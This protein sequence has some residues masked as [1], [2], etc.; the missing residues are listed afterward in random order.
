MKK[1]NTKVVVTQPIHD[2]GMKLLYDSIEE[3]VVAPDDSIETVGKLLDES[4]EGVVVRYNRFPKELIDKAPNLKVIARHGIGVELIDVKY[5]T[6]EGIYV[7]N[8][9]TASTISVAEHT[10]T[11]M[12]ALAKNILNADSEL[13]RGNYA[14][15][16]KLGCTDLENK[17]LGI[18]GAGKIGLEVAK[19]CKYGFNMNVIAY[20]PYINI[21]KAKEIGIKV[22]DTLDE[23]LENADYVSLH[24]PLTEKTK[25]MIGVK[26]L[27]K[28]K[29][30]AFLI[31]CGRGALVKED[32]LIKALENGDIAGAGIDVFEKEPPEK[33]NP[34]FKMKQVV[35]TPHSASLTVESMIKMAVGAA[36]QVVQVLKGEK[37]KY[38]VNKDLCK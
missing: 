15:K 6:K 33:D 4:V 2:E 31:N 11:L 32:D 23:L 19:K 10:V 7:V 8:T 26:E 22:V 9:P 5:A 37:P 3:V 34:L 27:K 25:Y 16:N 13:R 21:E 24:V 29:K 30:T 35:V 1:L 14:I 28:M 12:L 38:I 17:T 20:D 18:I 36:E